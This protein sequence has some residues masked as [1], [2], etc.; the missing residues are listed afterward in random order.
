MPTAFL[1]AMAFLEA[2]TGVTFETVKPILDAITDIITW[3]AIIAVLGGVLAVSVVFAF[4]W[5]AARKGVRMLMGAFKKGKVS[6]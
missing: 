4:S 6:V 5:W 3:D 2:T 1:T